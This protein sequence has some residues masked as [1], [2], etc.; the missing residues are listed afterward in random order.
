MDIR[1]VVSEGRSSNKE[2]HR[3]AAGFRAVGTAVEM[4]NAKTPTVQDMVFARGDDTLFTTGLSSDIAIATLSDYDPHTGHFAQ[5]GMIHLKVD[6]YGQTNGKGRLVRELAETLQSAP[7]VIIAFGDEYERDYYTSKTWAPA[8][9]NALRAAMEERGKT[10]PSKMHVLFTGVAPETQQ[11]GS[12]A[13][14]ADGSFGFLI[15]ED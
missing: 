13:L 14:G 12:F 1:N 4:C 11:P 9:L 7:Q 6:D 15:R 8:F 3:E 5:R 2:T 10:P